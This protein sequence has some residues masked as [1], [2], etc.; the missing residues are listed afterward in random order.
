[1][2]EVKCSGCGK[3]TPADKCPQLM[4]TPLCKPCWTNKHSSIAQLVEQVTVNHPVPGSSPGGGVRRG[5]S[6][7]AT[8]L[9]TL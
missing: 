3:M 5:M 4:M 1:M 8:V 7:P 9:T 2:W 6:S